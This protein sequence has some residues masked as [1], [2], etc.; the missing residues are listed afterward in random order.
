MANDNVLVRKLVGIET[1][2]N[3]N[4][5]FTDKTGTLTEGNM[6]LVGYATCNSE[7]KKKSIKNAPEIEKYITLCANYCTNAMKIDGK[8][9]SKDATERALLSVHSN[10]NLKT[11]IVEKIPFDSDK[12]YSAVWIKNANDEIVIFGLRYGRRRRYAHR[13]SVRIVT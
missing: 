7:Y 8:I 5:L 13:R 2:G 4:M 6:R 1:S 3:I 11:K 10:N 9:I 12:K